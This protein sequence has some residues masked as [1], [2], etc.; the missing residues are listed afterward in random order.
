MKIV[1]VGCG[2]VG[3]ALAQQLS[4]ENH[5]ITIIDT[6][7]E[8]VERVLSELDIQGVEGNG[9]TFVTQKE[10]GVDDCDL[11]IAVT[12]YDEVNLLCCL[13]AKRTGGCRTIARVRNPEYNAE[14]QYLTGEMGISMAINPE[15]ACAQSIAGLIEVPGALDL[16]SFAKGR[17]SLIK[18]PLPVD[19]PI[20]KMPVSEFAAKIKHNVLIC[21]LERRKKEESSERTVSEVIIPSGNTELQ[22]GDNM[23]I[24]VPPK[25]IHDVLKAI[26]IKSKPIRSVMITGGGMIAYYLAKY[27]V[28]DSVNVKILEQ[29]MERCEFL[30]AELPD[31]N[32]IHGN[33]SERRLLLE[34]GIQEQEAFVALTGLDEENLVLS[35][36]ANKVSEAKL[37]TKINKV[38]FEEVIR[39]LPIGTVVSPQEITAK[40]IL[41]YVRAMENSFGS[42]VETLYRM[43]DNKVE[44]LEFI[45]R[46]ES[47]V[48]DTPL[49]ELKLKPQLLI[50]AIVRRG[51]IITPGGR[52]MILNGDTVIVVTTNK[53]LRDIKD[54]L[55]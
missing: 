34:E 15:L 18:L 28:A 10:A 46:Q 26:G 45:I 21:A 32:V 16:M 40:S 52:D 53:G 2:K 41:Q 12:G 19:S 17:V 43:L 27:L 14:V 25:E 47:E 1:I 24:I 8:K 33:A 49:M 6:N 31:C 44:A 3:F 50:C 30:S 5:D 35:L 22:G 54:I 55:R 36:F 7:P 42:N 9:T 48:T 51:K 4:E 38:S 11:L 39:E 29:D 23:Y 20:H 37:V 13:V